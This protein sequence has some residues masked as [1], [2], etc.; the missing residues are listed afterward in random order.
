M[1]VTS[2]NISSIKGIVD[3][4]AFKIAHNSSYTTMTVHS[5]VITTS[6]DTV[7]PGRKT[8]Q[9]SGKITVVFYNALV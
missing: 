6:D 7:L 1:L 9:P 5:T 3:R 8:Y 4:P 2:D